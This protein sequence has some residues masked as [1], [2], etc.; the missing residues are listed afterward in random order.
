MVMQVGAARK[1]YGIPYPTLYAVP[2]T[3]R[4]YGPPKAEA[5]AAGAP[6]AGAERKDANI[7]AEEAYKFNCVQRA[8]QN[9]LENIPMIGLLALVSW[10]FRAFR[11]QSKG[12]SPR[13]P[14]YTHPSLTRSPNSHPRGL[15]PALLRLWPHLLLFRL[16]GGAREAHQPPLYPAY[17][18]RDVRALGPR[19]GHRDPAF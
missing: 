15:C 13:H 7:T 19:A 12:A 1:K 18:P 16:R 4:E 10:G 17:V 8:H 9:S 2:G 11:L 3:P 14:S 5:T 6:L